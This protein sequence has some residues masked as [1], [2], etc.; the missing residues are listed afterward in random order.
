MKALVMASEFNPPEG[1]FICREIE[2]GRMHLY[3]KIVWA[4]YSMSKFWSAL[5]ISPPAVSVVVFRRKHE[6]TDIYVHYFDTHNFG[7]INRLRVTDRKRSDMMERYNEAPRVA[8]QVFERVQAQTNHAL[9][10]PMYVM[11]KS[12][13]YVAPLRGRN[14]A[15]DEEEDSICE[16]KLSDMDP[17]GLDLNCI[18]RALLVKCNPKTCPACKSCQYQCFKRKQY[19]ELAAKRIPNKRWGLV[20]QEYIN[21]GQFVFNSFNYNF[22]TFG[23]QKKIYHCCADCNVGYLLECSNANSNDVGRNYSTSATPACGKVPNKYC[24]I[25]HSMTDSN[26]VE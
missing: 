3:D 16:C 10:S 11:I 2:S 8:R 17:C 26:L 13:K 19:P 25:D 20:A 15:G 5:N 1:R 12:N 6:K 4:K 7:C 21:Q 24:D 9:E 14:A 18:N 23:D 22:E